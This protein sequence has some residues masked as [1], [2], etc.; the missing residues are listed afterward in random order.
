MLLHQAVKQ[1]AFVNRVLVDQQQLVLIFHKNESIEQRAE[2][3]HGFPDFRKNR[4]DLFG[5]FQLFH[6]RFRA[7]RLFC[8]SI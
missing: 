3:L 2:N 6:S 8:S 4:V 7:F 5:C 1:Q